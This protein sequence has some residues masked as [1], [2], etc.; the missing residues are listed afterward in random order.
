MGPK[1]VL[2]DAVAIDSNSNHVGQWRVTWIYLGLFPRWLLSKTCFRVT[3]VDSCNLND[4]SAETDPHL[5]KPGCK[6][7]L[8]E[9]E[10]A[11]D[12]PRTLFCV[13]AL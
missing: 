6:T 7:A 3:C 10:G 2:Q 12:N 9:C 1:Q 5:S 8:V 4:M 11:S 13:S